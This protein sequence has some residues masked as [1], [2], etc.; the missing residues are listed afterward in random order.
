M[1]RSKTT[2]SERDEIRPSVQDS[3]QRVTELLRKHELATASA[4]RYY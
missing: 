3:L 4:L 2:M 1:Q